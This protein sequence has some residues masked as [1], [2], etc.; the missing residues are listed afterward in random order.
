MRLKPTWARCL[1]RAAYWS[2]PPGIQN[3]VW[4]QLTRDG[5]LSAEDKALVRRNQ[6]LRDQHRGER[7]FILATGP[8]IK[9]QN[10]KLLQGETCFAVSNFFVHPDCAIIQPRYYCIAPYHP[11]ITEDAWQ[12][13]LDELDRGTGSAVMFFGSADRQRN[14]G[15]GRFTDREI[16]YLAFKR[17]G[18]ME[19]VRDADISRAVPGPQS[20]TIMALL[21]ALY[22]GFQPIYLLGCDHDWILH[23]HA[24]SHFYDEQQSALNRSDYNEWSGSALDVECRSYIRLWQQYRALQSIARSKSVEIINATQGGLL[25]V[26]PRVS[27]E[28]LFSRDSALVALPPSCL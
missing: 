14:Q 8:S 24:S 12:A 3:A 21:V 6:A 16:Y 4:T 9:Q 11:P 17:Q 5:R 22:M 18:D 26:F 27:F 28:S 19:T 7:C 10:L 15:C 23:M 2:V 20:V 25:D 13:W 1:K